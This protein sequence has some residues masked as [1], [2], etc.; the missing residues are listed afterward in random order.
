MKK[1]RK[2]LFM[3][4]FLKIV[5]KTINPNLLK[6]LT[7]TSYDKNYI[8]IEEKNKS[9]KAKPFQIQGLDKQTIAF[10]FETVKCP[11]NPK[12]KCITRFPLFNR[13]E[14]KLFE[15]CDYVIVTIYNDNVYCLFLENKTKRYQ[16]SKVIKQL[17]KA[18][19]LW[20]YLCNLISLDNIEFNIEDI[21]YRYILSDS[22]HS[23]EK[24]YK[25]N[26]LRNLKVF[27]ETKVTKIPQWPVPLSRLLNN[28][29]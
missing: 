14:T 23:T 19:I 6:Q 8:V 29:F 25:K 20:D 21:K 11:Q 7:E 27:N 12:I 16:N 17:E 28:K 5:K 4:E 13:E 2:S 1:N 22:K 15:C 9:S 18:R 10:S 24:K 3:E 26:S